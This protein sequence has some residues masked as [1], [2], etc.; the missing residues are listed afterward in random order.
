MLKTYTTNYHPFKTLIFYN[1]FVKFINV[2]RF[3]H[4]MA[5]LGCIMFVLG[6]LNTVQA[7]NTSF[8]FTDYLWVYIMIHGLSI[9]FFS[10]LDAYGRYQNYK[11][12]KDNL[13]VY[14]FDRRL[15]KPFMYSKC[16][17]DAVLAASYDLNCQE[18]VK[19]FYYEKGYRWYHI[20]PDAFVNKPLGLKKK[21]L[22]CYFIYKKV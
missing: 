10:E 5:F 20:L 16:Q 6:L 12:I 14:G 9:P 2:G 21:V 11:Q 17:R 13:Y 1:Q 4:L 3:L 19:A 18:Q 22:A 7:I 15:I 8:N